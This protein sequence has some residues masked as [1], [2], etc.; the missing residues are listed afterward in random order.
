[1]NKTAGLTRKQVKYYLASA[2]LKGNLEMVK[3]MMNYLERIISKEGF[4]DVEEITEFYKVQQWL[5]E[6]SN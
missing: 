3:L 4:E 6:V 2:A 5:R 1:M